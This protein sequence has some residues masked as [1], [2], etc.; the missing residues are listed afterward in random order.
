LGRSIPV[1][2][3]IHLQ[4]TLYLPAQHS[5]PTPVVCALTPYVADHCHRHGM[6]FAAHGLPFLAV[7]VCGRGGSEGEFRPLVQEAK[8]GHDVVEWLARQS[9]CNGRVGMWG[10][11]YL[12]Y[13]QWAT[14]KERPMHLATIVPM[15]APFAGIDFPMRNNILSPFLVQWLALTSGPAS[16]AELFS[17]K[18]LWSAHFREWHESG[19]A[20]RELDALFGKPSSIFQEWLNHPE[21]DEYWAAQNPSAEQYARLEIPILTITGSYDD[22]QPG[23]LEHYRRYMRTASPAARARHYLIIGPWDHRGSAGTPSAE[24]GGLKVGAEALLDMQRLHRDWYAWTMEDG[25]KPAFLKKPVAYYVTGLEQWRYADT[26]EAI[27]ATHRPFFLD[28]AGSAGDLFSSGSLRA[29]PGTGAPDTYI[30]DPRARGAPEIA[31]EALA[32]GHSLV[33]QSVALALSGK[34][35]V[36]HSPPFDD[37]VEVSGFLRLTAWLAIDCPD[38]DFFVSVHEID[39]H[40]RAVRLSTDALRARYREGLERAKLV[41]THA[42]LRYDFDRFA[43]VARQIRRGHRL[44]LVI[45]PIGRL[46]EATFVQKNYN[47][48][49][50]VAEETAERGRAVTVRLFHDDEHPSALYLPLST[51][52]GAPT[53]SQGDAHARSL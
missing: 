23:A 4:A 30:Y 38:T 1:R 52:H 21:M 19:R 34:Q 15:A 40:G 26:L 18:T 6:Y 14:A 51:A 16:Q 45:A 32:D 28:S 36:Y 9:F 29:T 11:S 39:L 53:C 43:F 24:F 10:G 42:P 17:D 22:D 7:N 2:D 48:G 3:G 31:A 49:G 47:S 25:A 35:L 8:H 12:G 50:V 5:A 13:A 46:I 41:Q 37:D 33:D 44:R 27:T 20:F